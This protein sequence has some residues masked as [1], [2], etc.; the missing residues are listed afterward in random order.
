[1]IDEDETFDGTWPFAAHFSR[2]AGF[3]Q[4][5]VDEGTRSG[6]PIV[7][8]HGEPT[9]GYLWR[10]MIPLLS[11]THRVIAPD[12]M[13]FG[14][15]ADPVDRSYCAD[16]HVANLSSL[17]V[18]E[19]DLG[20]I[21]LVMHDWGGLIGMGF[22]LEHPGRIARIVAVNTFLPLGLVEQVEPMVANLDS[23]WFRWATQAN[24]D[25]SLEQILGNAGHTVTH[26]MLTLQRI[27]RPSIMAPVW[28]HAYSAHF[29]GP[30]ACRGA[31]RFPQQIVDPDPTPVP[32]PHPDAVAT[33]RSLPAMLAVGLQ[34]TALLPQ[35]VIAAFTAAYP[36][37][38]IIELPG[39]GH[40]PSEDSPD[41][42]LAA[43]QMF[44]QMTE[45]PI[46]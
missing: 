12:H 1:M 37:A 17:L 20:D 23:A 16:E 36:A 40:F 24:R 14:K 26:L 29:T 45:S 13:G 2:R 46:G 32:A 5:Y 15:S 19:L 43:I 11:R 6:K 41:A 33:L 10:Q 42:L 28:V 21:T 7:L 18:D 31:I 8:L 25:G 35:H 9:W 38:P 39:A 22:A 44:L 3:A 30:S 4:H 27:A 34:D